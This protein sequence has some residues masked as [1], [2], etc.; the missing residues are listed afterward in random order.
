MSQN[1]AHFFF[2]KTI[3]KLHQVWY[4]NHVKGR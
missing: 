2:E 1:L 4:Y 3:D